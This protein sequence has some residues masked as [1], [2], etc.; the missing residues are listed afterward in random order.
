MSKPALAEYN[1]ISNEWEGLNS[2]VDKLRTRRPATALLSDLHRIL[3][4]DSQGMEREPGC[5]Q[6]ILNAIGQD[7]HC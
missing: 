5:A 2:A 7:T 6:M 3:F 1:E 4:T